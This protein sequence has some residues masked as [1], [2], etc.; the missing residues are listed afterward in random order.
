MQS[1]VQWCPGAVR[2][3][4]RRGW[5][6]DLVSVPW[7]RRGRGSRGKVNQES[8]AAMR[9]SPHDHVRMGSL[10]CRISHEGAHVADSRE[11]DHLIIRYIS[12]LY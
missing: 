11:R 12:V 7:R 9:K 6:I 2:H 10:A 8:M 1:Y 3:N 5:I 4:F